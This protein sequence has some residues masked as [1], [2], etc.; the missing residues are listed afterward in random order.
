MK[1]YL[2]ILPYMGIV[3]GLLGLL[4]LLSFSNGNSCQMANSNVI[5]IKAHTQK[6][7]KTGSLEM[8]KYHAFKALSNLEKS[9]TYLNDCGCEPAL[10]TAKDAEQNLK[11]ATRS[12]SLKDSKGFLKLALQNTLI[13]IDALKNF[14]TAYENTYADDILVL[15]TKE[16]LRDQGGILLSPAKQMRNKMN[17]SLAEFETSL[18]AVV[19]HVDCEDA[20]NFINKIVGKSKRNLERNTLTEAQ[21]EYHTRVK[22]IA[23]DALRKLEGCPAK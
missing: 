9:K 19:Q 13:T 18:G 11:K 2:K 6:A 22:T 21:R 14:G 12:K 10:V 5:S 16:V 3:L 8:A 1:A 20:F 7:L 23:Y 17:Q 4:L 15:N